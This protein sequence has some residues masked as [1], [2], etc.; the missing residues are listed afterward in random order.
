MSDHRNIIFIGPTGAG[1]TGLA[2]AFL[3]KAID[4][5]YKGMFIMFPELQ[6]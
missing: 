1:K 5:G 6:H 3:T 4:K 2:T